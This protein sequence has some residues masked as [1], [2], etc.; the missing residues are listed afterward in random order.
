M[1]YLSG[2]LS[3]EVSYDDSISREQ[4]CSVSLSAIVAFGHEWHFHGPLFSRLREQPSSGTSAQRWTLASLIY[5]CLLMA[6][7]NAVSLQERFDN[8][9]HKVVQM[10]PG[11]KRP[12]GSYQGFV[13]ARRRISRRQIRM[14]KRQLCRH[15]RQIAGP[16]WRRHGWLVF[17]TDGTRIKLP[18]TA[19]NERAFGGATRDRSAPELSLTSLYHLGT[20][21]PWAWRIG[22]GPE[23]EQ[24]HLRRMVSWIPR[25]SLLVADAGFTSFDLLRLLQERGVEFLVR[26]G[27]NR[28][29][30]TGIQDA[31]V[32]VR[33]EWVWFW[34]QAKQSQAA[35]LVLRLLRIAQANH[36]PM[37]LVSSV[38]DERL[39]T[40]GQ[41]GR[42][43]RM[44][45]SQEVFH[46][47]FKRTLAQHTL[48]STS[49]GEARRELDWAVMAYWILGLWTVQAQIEAHRDPLNWSVAQALRIVRKRLLV[50]NPSCRRR[51]IDPL[52]R[53]VKDGY[54]RHGPKAARHWPRKKN[55]HPPG[56]PKMREATAHEK[57]LAL[58]TYKTNNRT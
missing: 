5:V 43:Y 29:L 39:L 45:W 20:G 52:R 21:L 37:C 48:R 38:L 10:F 9:R 50:A 47:S 18:R 32:R 51:W 14:L 26:M 31:T 42:F 34:P 53:A 12:G 11:R 36:S 44:R 1:L 23:S 49:P 41:I 24:V 56:L 35:P 3:K 57:H 22:P 13:A 27:S 2:Q 25:G 4:R 15:H 8:A 33:G 54:V 16:F 17:S 58:T 30:L 40:D 7:E 6:L 46:R 28:T 55:D 19:K